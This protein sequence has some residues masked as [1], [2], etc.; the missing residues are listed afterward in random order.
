VQRLKT[1]EQEN[2]MLKSLLAEAG[3]GQ[4]ALKDL[5]SQM[6]GPQA[7]R[8]VVTAERRKRKRIGLMERKSMPKPTHANVRWSMD[9]VADWLVDGPCFGVSPS[10]TTVPRSAWRT[11]SIPR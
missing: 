6:V 10:S 2:T 3:L 1:L 9:V 7:K 8:E 11:K 4:E 5:F